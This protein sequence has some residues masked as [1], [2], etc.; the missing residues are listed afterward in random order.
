MA[1]LV[2]I[3]VFLRRGNGIIFAES[4]FSFYY[5]GQVLIITRQERMTNAYYFMIEKLI[6]K[7]RE[8][9]FQNYSSTLGSLEFPARYLA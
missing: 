3:K 8:I 6:E 5:L 7:K 2:N 4:F 9:L 1:K